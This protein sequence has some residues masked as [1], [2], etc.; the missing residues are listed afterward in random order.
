MKK[1]YTFLVTSM[2]STMSFASNDDVVAFTNPIAYMRHDCEVKGK[3]GKSY[4]I[5]TASKDLCTNNLGGRYI[6]APNSKIAEVKTDKSAP[7]H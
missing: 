6:A 7:A 4:V 3:S 1:V 2:I 5:G